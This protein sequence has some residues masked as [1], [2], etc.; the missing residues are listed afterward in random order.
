[1]NFERLSLG[2]ILTV[3]HPFRDNLE[4]TISLIKKLFSTGIILIFLQVGCVPWGRVMN[5]SRPAEDSPPRSRPANNGTALGRA[6]PSVGYALLSCVAGT[7]TVVPYLRVSSLPKILLLI[8]LSVTY[9]VVMETSG[10]RQAVG[11]DCMWDGKDVSAL[12]HGSYFCTFGIILSLAWKYVLI[13]FEQTL[14][15]IFFSSSQLSLCQPLFIYL[16]IYLE[17]LQ[18]KPLQC[19]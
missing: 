2:S 10:Y 3:V 9:T 18:T 7:L 5:S 4:L 14:F 8:L 11:W 19:L 1:M 12:I 6:G 17:G 16:F 15:V 13:S